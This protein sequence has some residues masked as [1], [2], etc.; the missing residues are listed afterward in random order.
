MWDAS[1]SSAVPGVRNKWTHASG[2][3]MLRRL[4]VVEWSSSLFPSLSVLQQCKIDDELK[5]FFGLKS[6]LI[7]DFT[8]AIGSS[9]HDLLSWLSGRP[10]GPRHL[11][12]RQSPIL[13][14]RSITSGVAYQVWRR[15]P[16]PQ[17]PGGR[18]LAQ[19]W[20]EF[21]ESEAD[22]LHCP[23]YLPNRCISLGVV[24]IRVRDSVGYGPWPVWV[25]LTCHV[26]R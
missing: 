18:E 21:L 19:K 14:W 12:R 5:G 26:Q 17:R 4:I 22:Y 23:S 8:Y 25:L 13:R 24:Q 7:Q 20:D 1:P 11:K 2:P 3:V 9:S 6:G 16:G 10:T 15:V